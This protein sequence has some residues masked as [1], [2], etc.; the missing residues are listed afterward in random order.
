MLLAWFILGGFIFLFAPQRL[1]NKFQ[2]AFT[3]IFSWPLGISRS[4]TLQARTPV[5]TDVVSKREYEQ[6][7]NHL[8]NVL[9]QRDQAY[10]QIKVL[11]GLKNR[12][13]F[14]GTKLILAGIITC[15]IEESR[16]ELIINRGESDGLIKGQFVLGDNSVVGTI[17]DVSPR[18]AKVTLVT[19]PTSKIPVKIGQLDVPVLMKG[20]GNNIAKVPLLPIEHKVKTGDDVYV[21]EKSGWLDTPMITATVMQCKRDD[22]NP[23]IWDITVRPVCDIESLTNV[24]VIVMDPPQ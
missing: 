13:P 16:N 12:L 11:S 14:E 22:A 1:T 18:K 3:H 17:S 15:S 8:A 23:L 5:N 2:L 7:R 24:A 20:A 21:R 6:L 19:D 10:Q 4:I 9:Q